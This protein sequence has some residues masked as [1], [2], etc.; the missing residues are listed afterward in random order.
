MRLFAELV[1]PIYRNAEPFV[2]QRIKKEFLRLFEDMDRNTA[3]TSA[4]SLIPSSGAAA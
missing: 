3:I 1:E 2:R 4:V